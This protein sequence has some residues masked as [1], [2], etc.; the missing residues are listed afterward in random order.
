MTA[1]RSRASCWR[2]SGSST[3]APRSCWGRSPPSPAGAGSA[4]GTLANA[5]GETALLCGD[6][7]AAPWTGPFQELRENGRLERDDP[8]RPFEW[9][10]PVWNKLPRVPI[11]QCLAGPDLAVSSRTG[12]AI[13]SDHFPLLAAVSL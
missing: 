1:A 4:L 3:S 6:F 12:P 13:G 7:N 8:W 10:F 9:T 2:S 5:A 11:D